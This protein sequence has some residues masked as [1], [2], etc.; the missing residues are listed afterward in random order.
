MTRQQILGI[1][2]K[3]LE[4]SPDN[5]INAESTLCAELAGTR[6]YDQPIIGVA[7]AKDDYLL[8]LYTSPSAGL[9]QPPPTFWLK[10][11][12]SVISLFFPFTKKV[13]DSNRQAEWNKPSKEMLHAR[14]EGQA[15][16]FQLCEH[17]KKMLEKMGYT[18]VIPQRDPRYWMTFDKP[19]E[20]QTFTSNWSER[21][22][23]F[24]CGVGTFSL[25]DGIITKVGS[26][27]RLAS[28]VTDLELPVTTRPYSELYEY[29]TECG[30]CISNCPP[31]AILPQ[32]GGKSHQLCRSFLK[33][34]EEQYKDRAYI[35]C[36]G[37]CQINV[38]CEVGLPDA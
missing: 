20:G 33:V 6:I 10:D 16:I 22:V 9:P 2:I 5:K 12:K 31:G 27:G 1:A 4:E 37:K 34:V 13:R 36:C 7:S 24:A 25:H 38:P 26:A 14:N 8:G 11:A 30:L 32:V 29:C 15:F 35:G 3:Y 18:A 23:A 17:L 21:H 19:V 28:L